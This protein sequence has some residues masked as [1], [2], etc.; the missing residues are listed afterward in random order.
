MVGCPSELWPPPFPLYRELSLC[1]YPP[2]L[3]GPGLSGA[4]LSPCFVSL[5]LQDCTQVLACDGNTE[6]VRELKT[7][8]LQN[9][10]IKLQN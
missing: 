5:W 4:E 3:I 9:M 2:A 8:M 10:K 1:G 6:S 7:Y